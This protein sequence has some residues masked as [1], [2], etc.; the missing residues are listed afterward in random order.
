MLGDVVWFDNIHV[1]VKIVHGVGCWVWFLATR[2]FMV[3]GV[4]F[5]AF[6]VEDVLQLGWFQGFVE[7]NGQC[8]LVPRQVENGAII[9]V[10]DKANLKGEQCSKNVQR[11]F[12]EF[13]DNFSIKS[14]IKFQSYHHG[15]GSGL[16][17]NALHQI[18]II[19]NLLTNLGIGMK[20]KRSLN[21]ITA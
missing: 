14:S 11:M 6:F 19:N 4:P 21:I 7:M 3:F 17:I 10:L 2:I 20:K 12:K 18:N 8:L 16:G 9:V 15:L 5:I 1:E 13:Y